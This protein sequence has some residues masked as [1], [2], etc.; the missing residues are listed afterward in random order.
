MG[1]LL[2]TL[3]LA[4]PAAAAG[5]APVERALQ[6]TTASTAF[7][8]SIGDGTRAWT[9]QDTTAGDAPVVLWTTT[10]DGA[11]RR[12]AS[13]APVAAS[14]V[15]GLEVGASSDGIPVAALATHTAG[16][17]RG[18]RLVRL[19][20]GAVRRISST[21]RGEPIGGMAIDHGRLSYALQGGTGRK[22]RRSTLWRAPLRATSIGR[23]TRVRT[24]AAGEQWRRVVADRGRIAVEAA[25]PVRDGSGISATVRWRFGTP[26]GTWR[27]TAR[28]VQSD[29][30]YLRIDAAGFTADRHALVTVQEQ[31]DG[32]PTVS[33]LPLAGGAVRTT[34]L[35]DQGQGILRVPALDPATGRLL[36]RDLDAAGDVVVGT[37]AVLFR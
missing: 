13:I 31:E 30:G 8:A 12:V 3:A 22:A 23:A 37:S 25:R 19:D 27:R 21:R 11:P 18:L 20:T 2:T 28:T 32:G 24:S 9:T 16:G 36:T 1:A 17:A 14:G 35:G 7:V 33:R 6:P 10:A 34:T 5:T 29:G 15:D 26:R 4:S